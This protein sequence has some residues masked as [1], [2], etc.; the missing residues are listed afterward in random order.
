MSFRIALVTHSRSPREAGAAGR[1]PASPL[2]TAT[3]SESPSPLETTLR[4]LDNRWKPLIVWHLFWEPHP[5]GELLRRVEGITKKTL[6]R[7]LTQMQGAGLVSTEARS[8]ARRRLLYTLT[9]Y[10]QTLKP[11]VAIMYEWGLR[12]QRRPGA[13]IVGAGHH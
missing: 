2:R 10:G 1:E 6:R 4:L 12:R 13:L 7:E 5:F 8:T 11:I 9:P 3:G